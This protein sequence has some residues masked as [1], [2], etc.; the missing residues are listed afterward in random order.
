[1]RGTILGGQHAMPA[2]VVGLPGGLR[3]LATGSFHS[4]V[5]TERDVWCW[6]ANGRGEL[7]DGTAADRATPVRAVLPGSTR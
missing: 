1:G 2:D 5:R 4:C 7:G 3:E 6:G